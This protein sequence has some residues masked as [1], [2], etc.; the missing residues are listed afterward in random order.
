MRKPEAELVGAAAAWARLDRFL[1]Q[2]TE[3]DARAPS[4]LDGWTRAHIVAHL[5][6]NAEGFVGLVNAAAV[7]RVGVHYPGG[8]EGRLRDIAGRAALPLDVILDAAR[9]SQVG[10]ADA[11]DL[12]A[13]DGWDQP[14]RFL[15]GTRPVSDTA[16][17]RWRETV[18]HHV[19]LDVGF[20]PED[21][22]D[23]YR[24]RDATWLSEHRP[25]WPPPPP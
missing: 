20:E 13:S 21:L 12:V 17:V 2:L 9:V 15:D 24:R 3:A 11:W 22:P 23:D 25:D 8:P 5:W 6:G 4:R 1:G 14:S 19:D 7:G 10:L 16:L 18:V